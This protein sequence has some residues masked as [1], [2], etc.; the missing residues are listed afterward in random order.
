M[1]PLSCNISAKAVDL[2]I[3]TLAQTRN[4]LGVQ[5]NEILDLIDMKRNSKYFMR[6]LP[7]KYIIAYI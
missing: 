4:S 1:L 5:A 3:F 2:F 7:Q 6:L